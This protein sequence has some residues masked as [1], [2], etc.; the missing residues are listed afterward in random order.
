[1]AEAE[2]IKRIPL[3]R[4]STQVSCDSGMAS[5]AFDAR[6]TSSHLHHRGLCQ[7]SHMLQSPSQESLDSPID[8]R[9]DYYR[10]TARQ[11]SKSHRP[12]RQPLVT[13][14]NVLTFIRLLLVPVLGVLWFAEIP[15]SAFCCTMV[16]SAASATDWLDGF[17]ARK[18]RPQ[19]HGLK[20]LPRMPT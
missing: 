5:Y 3:F 20:H 10:Q 13:L 18:V 14:P 16:F 8:R 4:V 2:E 19:A 12:P 7:T 9:S 15:S 11:T 17:L 6:N 1:M